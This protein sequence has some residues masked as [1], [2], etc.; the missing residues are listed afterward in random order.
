MGAAGLVAVPTMYFRAM[1]PETLLTGTAGVHSDIYQAGLLLYRMSNGEPH[2][3]RQ[4]AQISIAALDKLITK[5]RFPDRSSFQPHIPPR[6]R[7]IIRKALRVNP[8]ERY[9][10][11]F[12]LSDDLARLP[13]PLDWHQTTSSSG[14]LEWRAPGILGH[15]N[16][17]V[18]QVPTG[19]NN[20]NVEV[21]TDKAGKRRA[22]SRK[23]FWKQNIS[24]VEAGMH[25][26]HLF[27][28]LR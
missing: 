23:D 20:W 16:L 28:V 7:T 4:V 10:S 14:L 21:F 24:E 8:S 13:L 12:D 2:Y 27:S 18:R 19:A 6:L 25:L 3:Q 5:A 26:D 22:K 1:P 15:A 17:I 11:A 9:S